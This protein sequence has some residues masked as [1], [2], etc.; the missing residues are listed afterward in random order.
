MQTYILV[1]E[2]VRPVRPSRTAVGEPAQTSAGYVASRAGRAS[3]HWSFIPIGMARDHQPRS[4]LALFLQHE[5]APMAAGSGA[6]RQPARR[7][8]AGGID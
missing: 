6:A 8:P 5:A 1:S 4:Q 2:P 3:H 7:G